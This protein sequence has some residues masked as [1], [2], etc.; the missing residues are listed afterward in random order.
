VIEAADLRKPEFRTVQ[1]ALRVLRPDW[2]QPRGGSRTFGG[3]PVLGV[4]IE[5]QDKGYGVEKL[6]ELLTANV[7]RVRRINASE[8]MATYGTQWAW[9]GLV[10]TMDRR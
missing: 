9:G 8:S 6:Q 5:G 10:V 4:F 2:L 7:R 3:T 1:D